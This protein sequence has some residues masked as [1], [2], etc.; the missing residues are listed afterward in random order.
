M[1]T[2]TAD[3]IFD[4]LTGPAPQPG[5]PAD[6]VRKAVLKPESD[7]D[8]AAALVRFRAAH[9]DLLKAP[10]LAAAVQEFRQTVLDAVKAAAAVAA[11]APPPPAAP[12]T[13]PAMPALPTWRDLFDQ[14]V[15]HC[16]AEF[17]NAGRPAPA[18][19]PESVVSTILASYITGRE[20]GRYGSLNDPAQLW[21]VLLEIAAKKLKRRLTPDM[22]ADPKFAESLSGTLKEAFDA[23]DD[24]RRKLIV[25]HTLFGRSPNEIAKLTDDVPQDVGNVVR[26]LHAKLHLELKV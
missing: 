5:T 9:T 20:D 22:V 1:S 19:S 15:R 4:F 2:P 25:A 14:L 7:P 13:K 16:R 24:E 26:R 6:R 8:A 18:G 21:P 3:D 23:A 11:T 12:G 10:P 17:A